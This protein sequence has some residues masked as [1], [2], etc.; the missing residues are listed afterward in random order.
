MTPR[1]GDQ[2]VTLVSRLAWTAPH[3][4]NPSGITDEVPHVRGVPV[5]GEAVAQRRRCWPNRAGILESGDDADTVDWYADLADPPPNGTLQR[6]GASIPGNVG[7][8]I[9]WLR[10]LMKALEQIRGVS[11]PIW[12]DAACGIVITPGIH[13]D[14]RAPAM[15][16]FPGAIAAV[17][18]HLGEFPG[19]IQLRVTPEA[20]LHADAY[21]VTVQELLEEKDT[22]WKRSE[23]TSGDP[24]S[25]ERRST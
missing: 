17:P 23:S 22:T 2:E 4:S 15:K 8:R 3:R 24:A 1:R 25:R 5:V 9:A 19:G 6:H 11:S 14:R 10:R 12:P 21:A 7:E 13:A 16:R 18:E 20:W